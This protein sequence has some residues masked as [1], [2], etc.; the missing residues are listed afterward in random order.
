[1][2][3]CDIQ[4]KSSTREMIKQESVLVEIF[5]KV[6]RIIFQAFSSKLIIIFNNMTFRPKIN[7]E[8]KIEVEGN[9]EWKDLY[10]VVIGRTGIVH[11]IVHKLTKKQIDDKKMQFD[12]TATSWMVPSANVIV[13]YIQDNGEIIYD[14]IQIDFDSDMP[15]NVIIKS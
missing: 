6:Q 4:Q 7:K 8:V 9:G 13:Y 5:E 12:F 15:N 3:F 1:M 14:K 2:P 10:S 11:N